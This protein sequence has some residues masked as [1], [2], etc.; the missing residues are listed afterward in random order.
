MSQNESYIQ[1]RKRRQDALPVPVADNADDNF[2]SARDEDF[3]DFIPGVTPPLA[4]DPTTPPKYQQDPATPVSVDGQQDKDV[5]VI[6]VD[7]RMNAVLDQTQPRMDGEPTTSQPQ[8][9]PQPARTRSSQLADEYNAL[10]SAPVKDKNGKFK[11]AILQAFYQM[12]QNA[13]AQLATGHPIDAY[14]LADIIGGGIGGA[15]AGGVKPGLDEN[16]KRQARLNDLGIQIRQQLGVE[17]QQ[18]QAQA[19]EARTQAVE[20]KNSP[21]AQAA[22]T[23]SQ[24]LGEL[25]RRIRI[26]GGHLDPNDAQQMA[27]AQQLGI[28]PKQG[29]AGFNAQRVKAIRGA[30]GQDRLVYVDG[31]DDAHYIDV[32]GNPS[33]PLS[34]RD[35]KMLAIELE[36]ENRER[37]LDGLPPLKFNDEPTPAQPPTQPGSTQPAPQQPAT[38]PLTQSGIAPRSQT[39]TAPVLV[40]S[41][42]KPEPVTTAPIRP[43]Q[44]R[45]SSSSSSSSGGQS[46][47]QEIA[48]TTALSSVRDVA[49]MRAQ[50]D[51]A[52]SRGDDATA[53]AYD[54]QA[55]TILDSTVKAR[56][57]IVDVVTDSSGRRT[58]QLKG[59]QSA[60]T[61]SASRSNPMSGVVPIVGNPGSQP[62]TQPR[63]GRV[64]RAKFVQRNPQFKGK[65]QQEID[66]AIMGDGFTPIP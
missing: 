48:T 30:D 20:A 34:E 5:A 3:Y 18:A 12:G 47:S 14:G 43:R 7:E 65:P 54:K 49:N 64:S 38:Q 28:T 55:D 9:Q 4:V 13:N 35:T 22:R 46:K 23:R 53:D 37:A 29:G 16:R 63:G 41:G 11:S 44:R 45:R 62:S 40:P 56:A 60:P 31:P 39:T 61:P 19:I 42:A 51:A 2:T 33:A 25:S 57:G 17:R 21:D 50:A 59:A 26:G 52:R 6:P 10:A 8:S 15:V 58:L 66:A 36:R 27:L 1:P 32:P 24:M